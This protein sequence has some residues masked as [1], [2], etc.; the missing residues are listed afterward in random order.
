MHVPSITPWQAVGWTLRLATAAGLAIDAYV[1]ADLVEH[2]AANKSAGTLSQGD[3]FHIES[4]VASFAALLIIVSAWR[5][6]WAF[7]ALIAASALAAITISAN[8]DIGTIGPIPD[9]YEPLWYPEKSLTAWAEAIATTLAVTGFILAPK[10]ARHPTVRR[11]QQ[12]KERF[13]ASVSARG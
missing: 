8:Y 3:L 6:I 5:E 9:M 7:A 12:P 1:H 2:Y 4:G 11:K 10:F 13:D